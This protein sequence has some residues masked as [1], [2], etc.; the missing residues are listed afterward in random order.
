[1][2]RTPAGGSAGRWRADARG[3]GDAIG[4]I[5]DVGGPDYDWLLSMAMSSRHADA[6]SA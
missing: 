5:P 6:V 4:I 1:M 3:S 2:A